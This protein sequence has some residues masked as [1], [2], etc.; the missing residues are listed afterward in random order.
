M[1]RQ[2]R[3]AHTGLPPS[4]P[5]VDEMANGACDEVGDHPETPAT[6]L[7]E[8]ASSVPRTHAPARLDT[9]VL[10]EGYLGRPRSAL[11]Q[12]YAIV[13]LSATGKPMQRTGHYRDR[14][15]AAM[16]RAITGPPMPVNIQR[17]HISESPDGL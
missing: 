8:H 4:C 17:R 14:C 15:R 9:G 6:D 12:A 10:E 13:Q 7:S 5:C 16:S 1:S 11:N 2:C 3:R